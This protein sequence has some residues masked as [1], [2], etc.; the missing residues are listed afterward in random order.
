VSSRVHMR[1]FIRKKLRSNGLLDHLGCRRVVGLC[2]VG[3]IGHWGLSLNLHPP[4][5]VNSNVTI[6]RATK[7][8][9]HAD[10]RNSWTSLPPEG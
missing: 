9:A 2:A 5:P 7:P 6:S 3:V 4:A 8:P 10:T 1:L